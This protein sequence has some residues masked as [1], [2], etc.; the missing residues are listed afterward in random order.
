M[1]FIKLFFGRGEFRRDADSLPQNYGELIRRLD[2]AASPTA[3]IFTPGLHIRRADE[4][5][6]A[7]GTGASR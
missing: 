3:W 2:P 1:E 6:N 4:R 5:L 7:R